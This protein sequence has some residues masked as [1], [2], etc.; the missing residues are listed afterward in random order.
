MRGQRTPLQKVLRV[1][2]LLVTYALLVPGM[3]LFEALGWLP[4]LLDWIGRH[5]PHAGS[6]LSFWEGYQP[7]AHDVIVCSYLKSGTN[8]TLQIAQQIAWRGRAEFEH[9][10]DVVP[11]P[12]QVLKGYAIPLED[13]RAASASPTGLRVIK[14]HARWQ[15]IPYS[16]DAKYVLVVRDPKDAFVSSHHFIRDALLGPLMPSVESWY[17]FF[18]SRSFPAGFWAEHAHSYWSARD[19]PNTVFLTF[20]E[21]KADLPGAVRKVAALLDVD[22]TEEELAL[23]CRRSSFDFMKGVDEKF[24][25]GALTP[26][27]PGAG[28]VRRGRQG[29]AGEM[30]SLAQQR[31]MDRVFRSALDEMGSDF[32]Y[33]RACTEP[34]TTASAPRGEA[35]GRQEEPPRGS[36]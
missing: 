32:D 5:A 33:D 30:L 1:P 34:G 23:V 24:A 18:L 25:P 15:D 13:T 36:S 9:I 7:T 29:G 16:K 11:W 14:T 17:A 20:K 31:R 3:K 22:L 27:S 12:D 21:M 2:I 10:H 28:L 4:P 19:L 8:W 6:W 26:L 35:D